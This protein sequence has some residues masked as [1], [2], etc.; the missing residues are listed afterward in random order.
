MMLAA[1]AK[2]LHNGRDFMKFGPGPATTITLISWVRNAYYK[3]IQ[4]SQWKRNCSTP[5]SFRVPREDHL[6]DYGGEPVFD[7]GPRRQVLQHVH[8]DC[9]SRPARRPTGGPAVEGAWTRA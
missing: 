8:E 3:G 4:S 5:L 6:Q 1:L 7:A 2:R 9:A